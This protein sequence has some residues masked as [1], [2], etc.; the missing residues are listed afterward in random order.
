MSLPDHFRPMVSRCA[1]TLVG[2]A[3]VLLRLAACRL[4]AAPAGRPLAP[5]LARAVTVGLWMFCVTQIFA[6]QYVDYRPVW[7]WLNLPLLQ[8]PFAGL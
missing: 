5:A 2:P 4:I 7:G 3:Y 6:A 8:L 1:S